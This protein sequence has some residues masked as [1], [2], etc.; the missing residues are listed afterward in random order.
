MF[1]K[2]SNSSVNQC[3]AVVK[4]DIVLNWTQTGGEIKKKIYKMKMKYIV[5]D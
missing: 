2:I 4:K 1:C 5:L 3:T